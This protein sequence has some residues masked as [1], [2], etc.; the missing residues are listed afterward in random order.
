MQ[1]T[2][3]NPGLYQSLQ[4][5]LRIQ[6]AVNVGVLTMLTHLRRSS[7]LAILLHRLS[8]AC[9]RKGG[10]GKIGAILFARLNLFINNCDIQAGAE[11]GPGFLMSHPVGIVIGA[12]KVGRHVTMQQHVTLGTKGFDGDENATSSYPVIGDDV[13]ISVGAAILGNIKIGKGAIIG[14]NAVVLQDVP[15]GCTAVGVPARI[16]EK[17]KE[18]VI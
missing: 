12:A 11:I 17:R 9:Y 6:K 15:E 16:L 1:S 8:A 5:D 7:F 3:P 14:A 2:E 10:L 4:E 18:L 13:K